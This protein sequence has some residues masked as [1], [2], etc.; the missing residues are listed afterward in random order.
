VHPNAHFQPGANGYKRNQEL[1]III[2]KPITPVE[3]K[4]NFLPLELD[5]M[6]GGAF[7]G[8]NRSLTM[9]TMKQLTITMAVC[10]MLGFVFAQVPPARGGVPDA[11][12]AAAFHHETRE[13]QRFGEHF[14]LG[15]NI[16]GM[17]QGIQAIQN[18]GE[19][20]LKVDDL[21]TQG[22]IDGPTADSLDESAWSMIEKTVTALSNVTDC[23]SIADLTSEVNAT[24][25]KQDKKGQLINL[26]DEVQGD[27]DQ[28][29]AQLK[30]GKSRKALQ[31]QFA[32]I[33]QLGEFIEKVDRFQQQGFIDSPT[34]DALEMCAMN[35][36]GTVHVN[37]STGLVAYYPFN[38]DANDASGNGNN[39]TVVGATFQTYGAAGK[40]ALQLSGNISSYVLVPRS[41]SLEPVDAISISMWVKGVPGE[42]C[43]YGW[44]TILRKAE[45]C[46]PGY[47]IRG[48]NGGTAFQ[49]DGADP[50]WV[51]S[52]HGQVS[53]LTFTGTSW[54]HIVATYSRTDGTIKSYEDGVLV[55]QTPLAS[56][57]LHSGNL[58]IGGAAVAGD[59]GGFNGLI[60]EVQIYNH[61]LS[62]SEVQQLYL[63]GSGSHP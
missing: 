10:W 33:Q 45:N 19:F 38:G 14:N 22:F 18:L 28:A 6:S 41:T 62:A 57:L 21:Q 53:F 58:Y 11:A 42:P 13:L 24:G 47:F 17:V 23:H 2:I 15:T 54:Q 51:P 26:L 48:C 9:K 55:N 35:L 46:S 31:A 4:N 27:T 44:G 20:M 52:Y 49:L 30:A 56:Q 5:G 39:G 43:G 34:A 16:L 12:S 29:Q 8:K 61:A 50:C 36:V 7:F 59:D 37:L 3:L 25:L 63:S 1:E 60:N 32:A 40:M